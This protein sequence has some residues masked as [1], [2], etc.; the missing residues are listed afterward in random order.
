[1][2]EKYILAVLS[3]CRCEGCFLHQLVHP[4]TPLKGPFLF[5]IPM[6]L[7][8]PPMPETRWCDSSLSQSEHP[9]PYSDWFRHEH[10][11]PAQPIKINKSFDEKAGR[12]AG[13]E[14]HFGEDQRSGS[15]GMS[16]PHGEWRQFQKAE[17]R[18][19]SLMM[20]SDLWIQTS[21]TWVTFYTLLSHRLVNSS[22]LA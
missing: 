8:P 1:M 21:Q 5:P 2:S 6:E 18:N 16:C 11:T 17:P 19:Q 3:H 7:A 12:M 14:N 4:N 22:I 15:S 10:I 9:F 20:S 13:K